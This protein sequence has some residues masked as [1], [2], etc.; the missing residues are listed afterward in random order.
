LIDEGIRQ[1]ATI[2]ISAGKRGLQLELSPDDLIKL[3]KAT[4]ITLA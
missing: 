2:Y 4:V 1:H 3:T